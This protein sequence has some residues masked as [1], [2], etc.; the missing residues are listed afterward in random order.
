MEDNNKCNMKSIIESYENSKKFLMKLYS[1]CEE[2]ISTIKSNQKN[3]AVLLQEKHNVL[4]E[5][6][7]DT[8]RN[9]DLFSPIYQNTY[10]TKENINME[11]NLIK[12]NIEKSDIDQLELLQRKR[13]LEKTTDCINFL[14]EELIDKSNKDLGLNILEAQ[15]KERQRI[16]GDLHDSTVQNLTSL[17]HKTELCIKLIDIDLVRAKLELSTM[18]NTIKSI[19]NDMRNIIFNLKPMTLCDL[20]LVLTVNQ[21][22]KKLASENDIDIQFSHNEEVKNVIPIINTT[23]FRIIKEAC[24]NVIKHA[25]ATLIEINICYS[26][27]DIEVSIKDNG[28]G[29][30]QNILNDENHQSNFGLPIMK[31][32]IALL[33]GILQLQTDKGKGTLI[34]VSVPISICK[35]DKHEQTN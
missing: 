7:K 30:D 13:G 18:S 15:E 26:E 23:I 2:E 21:F 19:I 3:N 32:R 29:F 1:E 9:L 27:N 25:N 35:G 10:N 22:T 5:R 12:E 8:V 28:I 31:E 33:S 24:Y 34:N 11:I 6:E 14:M 17:V 16:A 4:S 20:G